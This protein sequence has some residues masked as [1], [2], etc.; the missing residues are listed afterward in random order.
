MNICSLEVTQE[1]MDA[2]QHCE[3]VVVRNYER[4]DG[5]HY[6]SLVAWGDESEMQDQADCPHMFIVPVG[7]SSIVGQEM[8]LVRDLIPPDDQ[9]A[10]T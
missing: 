1:E 4:A 6:S 2:I 8:V 9:E 3:A 7:W 10:L 5:S